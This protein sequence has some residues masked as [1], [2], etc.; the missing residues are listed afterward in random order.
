MC[1]TASK[2]LHIWPDLSA[3]S[4][5][6]LDHTKNGFTRIIAIEELAHVVMPC[7]WWYDLVANRQKKYSITAIMVI[8]DGKIGRTV[9]DFFGSQSATAT[10]QESRPAKYYLYIGHSG[11]DL[12]DSLTSFSLVALFSSLLRPS[13]KLGSKTRS[14]AHVISIP[15]MTSFESILGCL[16]VR[17]SGFVRIFFN[18]IFR[19]GCFCEHDW[20]SSAWDQMNSFKKKKTYFREV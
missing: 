7:S 5:H 1:R 6:Q 16:S 15:M 3:G 20:E 8:C 19:L 18:F 13:S 9:V 10:A 2:R 11:A 4:W 14:D 12:L 17:F